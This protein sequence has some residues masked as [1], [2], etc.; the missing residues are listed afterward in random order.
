MLDPKSSTGKT[1][2]LMNLTT[3]NYSTK[4]N[5]SQDLDKDIELDPEL[6]TL[7]LTDREDTKGEGFGRQ[8]LPCLPKVG[9]SDFA[10]ISD[11]LATPD[12]P[13]TQDGVD[14]FKT[15]YYRKLLSRSYGEFLRELSER[16]DFKWFATLTFRDPVH[17]EQAGRRFDRWVHNL[18]RKVYGV[19]YTGRKQGVRWIRAIEWQRREVIHFHCLIADIPEVWNPEEKDFRRLCW[20]DEWSKENGYARIYPYDKSLGACYYLGK[21]IGKGGEID[22]SEN[23][24]VASQQQLSL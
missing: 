2:Q 23:I 20:M 19:R 15:Y 12:L 16:I 4:N 17:P 10:G 6:P 9:T 8:V 21:Y 24:A 14:F 3:S 22:Y 7:G 1:M 5:K 18:N 11:F 13:S